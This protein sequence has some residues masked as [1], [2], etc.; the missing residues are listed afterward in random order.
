MI[1]GH[2]LRIAVIPD[3]VAVVV[4][5]FFSGEISVIE[6]RMSASR[7]NDIVAEFIGDFSL[8]KSLIHIIFKFHT[9]VIMNKLFPRP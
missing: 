2:Y 8:F 9:L 3:F 7:D 1:D 5:E 6:C 4:I